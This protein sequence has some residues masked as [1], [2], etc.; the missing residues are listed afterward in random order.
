VVIY[1]K[2]NK[3]KKISIPS[4]PNKYKYYGAQKKCHKQGSN[5]S[6]NYAITMKKSAGPAFKK[7]SGGSLYFFPSQCKLSSISLSVIAFP[8]VKESVAFE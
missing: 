8:K 6:G 2:A 7:V 5:C 3:S 4:A 1:A